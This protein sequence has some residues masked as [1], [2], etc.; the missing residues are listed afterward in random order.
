LGA[1]YYLMKGSEPKSLYGE[2]AHIITRV[3]EHRQAE[4]ALKYRER[5]LAEA[6]RI[7]R[8]GSWEWDIQQNAT[9]WS[10][11]MYQI[12][13]VNTNTFAVDS[14]A[15]FLSCVHPEDRELVDQAVA[16]A[17]AEQT[18]FLVE[19]R[20]IRP[21]GEI[22][23]IHDRGK[24]I[25]DEK[26][27]AVRMF[28]TSQDITERKRAEEALTESESQNRAIL[29]VIPDLVF[30]YSKDGTCLLFR[31][32]E[33]ELVVPPDEFL[34]KKIEEFLPEISQL[35][36]TNIEKTLR[37]GEPQVYEYSLGLGDEMRDWEGRMVP[38]GEETVLAI[39]R[40][41]TERKQAE[42]KLRRSEETA[43]AI[44]NASTDSMILLD[45]AGTI[46]ATN[47]AQASDVGQALDDLPGVCVYDFFPPEMAKSRKERIDEVIR[48]GKPT[49]F[50]DERERRIYDNYIYP[51]LEPHRK[52]DRV[53]VFARDITARK[54]A[55]EALRASE[56]KYREL[57]EK[58]HEG[59]LVED[60][61]SIITFVNRRTAEVLGYS[62]NELIKQPLSFLVPE[63][64]EEKIKEEFTK[65][66]RGLSSIYETLIRAKDDR[67]IPA[68]ISTA[69]LFSPTGTFRGALSVF[70]DITE[71][72]ETEQKIQESERKYRLMV[73]HSLQGVVIIQEV[74]IVY[75]NPAFEGMTGYS[76]KEL[77][78]LSPQELAAHVHPDDQDIIWTDFRERMAGKSGPSRYEFRFFR[79][80]RTLC[81]VEAFPT[82]IEYQGKPAAQGICIDITERKQTEE[83]LTRQKTEL[84][85][86]TH[87]MA[88]DLRNGLF[89]IE[90]YADLLR[91]EAN[92]A[93]A[94]KIGQLAQRMNALLTRS[95][96]LADA[97][98]VIDK[99]AKINLTDLLQEVAEATIPE[100]L[101]FAQDRLPTV[102]GDREKLSQVFQNL[103]ENAVIHGRPR[104]IEVR[105]H[106]SAEGAT[107]LVTND[108]AP[109][110]HE[111]HSKI[112][113]QGFTT[114]EEGGG[115]GLGIVEKVVKAHGWDISLDETPET[116]FRIFIPTSKE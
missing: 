84:S 55:E 62:K 50:E 37:T 47:E 89:S 100:S 27:R 8:L 93:Y 113:Q 9:I 41:I 5:Q 30:Q 102:L 24:V 42:E 95:V 70:T 85:E 36:M 78:A 51:I 82:R 94:E 29:N 72:K 105:S 90:G 54:L 107:L 48:H 112:F 106:A 60:T 33:D 46:I 16:L 17:L 3:I 59:V 43:R 4:E 71:R 66:P 26:G 61:D 39:A 76:L 49:R 69:P 115:L 88:H 21:D 31:G 44:I 99:T 10:N 81:W 73:D 83:R 23:F 96:N 104:K 45:A 38:S 108:G 34:G 28:G 52:V 63:S 67:L 25:W 14:H 116:T 91:G 74:R 65:R 20:I 64:E 111:D 13:G 92:L 110:P 22:R 86:F 68:I 80:N 40:E 87:A 6:Q 32:A 35:T 103:F 109:I 19:Y 15:A 101:T 18:P 77:Q 114:K 75:A 98:L 53:A 56:E 58:M 97:G 79:K 7:A 2:L 11:G 57:V 12:F 1:D